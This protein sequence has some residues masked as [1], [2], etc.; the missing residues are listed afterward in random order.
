MICEDKLR[1]IRELPSWQTTETDASF[2]DTEAH[3]PPKDYAPKKGDKE[4]GTL[5]EDFGLHDSN[6]H[7]SNL[8][9]T[10]V[11]DTNKA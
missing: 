6:L 1:S 4:R 8:H 3:L 2:G 7:D 9:E 10:N 5:A 11:E